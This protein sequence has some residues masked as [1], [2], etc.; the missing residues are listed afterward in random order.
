MPPC[1]TTTVVTIDPITHRAG[2]QFEVASS[3]RLRQF[4]D[5]DA[6]LRPH[7]AAE[8]L[9]EAAVTAARASLVWL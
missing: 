6:R 2:Q 8:R 9:T 3:I 4:R 7:V 5:K 1:N